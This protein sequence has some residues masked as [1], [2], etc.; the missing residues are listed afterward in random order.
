MDL[1]TIRAFSNPLDLGSERRLEVAK[2]GDSGSFGTMR[3]LGYQNSC[4]TGNTIVLHKG[5][6]VPDVAVRGADGGINGTADSSE[7]ALSLP[8]ALMVVIIVVFSS[9]P[10]TAEAWDLREVLE[11]FTVPEELGASIAL[12]SGL[13]SPVTESS[14]RRNSLF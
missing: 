7:A 2:G 12:L 11:C 3:S 6:V 5:T 9:V 8:W 4:G 14:L 10:F 13:M 1:T